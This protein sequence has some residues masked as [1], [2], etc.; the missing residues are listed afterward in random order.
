MGIDAEQG[1]ECIERVILTYTTIQNDRTQMPHL[2]LNLTS[3]R[4]E[5]SHD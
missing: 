4:V 1:A 2:F 5:L 3:C